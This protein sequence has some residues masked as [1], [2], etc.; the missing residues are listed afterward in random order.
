MNNR[1]THTHTCTHTHTHTHAK[2]LDFDI[3]WYQINIWRWSTLTKQHC[4]SCWQTITIMCIW[5][6][7]KTPA[8]LS[9]LSLTHAR[10]HARTHTHTHTRTHARTHAHTHTHTHTG[11]LLHS[12]LKYQ[13]CSELFFFTFSHLFF[14]HKAIRKHY[15]RAICAIKQTTNSDTHTHTHTCTHT[16]THTHFCKVAIMN[17]CQSPADVQ[18][19]RQHIRSREVG[20][21]ALIG[22]RERKCTVTALL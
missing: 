14:K 4:I 11:T 15:P 19:K 6:Q 12:V 3:I 2:A 1:Y 16:H 8:A 20:Y 17:Y 21:P 5:L 9:S 13:V 18:R 7:C 10:T 22:K